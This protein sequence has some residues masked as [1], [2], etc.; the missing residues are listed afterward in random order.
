MLNHP[1]FP[2]L[3][4]YLVTSFFSSFIKTHPHE[5]I[6]TDCPTIQWKEDSSGFTCWAQ[7]EAFFQYSC[8]RDV[9]ALGDKPINAFD[10]R[11]KC[12]LTLR[13]LPHNFLIATPVILKHSPS[14]VV[15][16]IVVRFINPFSPRRHKATPDVYTIEVEEGQRFR[17]M[18]QPDGKW[19]LQ[20]S[21]GKDEP[22][23]SINTGLHGRLSL[24][25]SHDLKKLVVLQRNRISTS[26]IALMYGP[27]A[28]STTIQVFSSDGSTDREFGVLS[29][30]MNGANQGG[31][32][33]A[34][35]MVFTRSDVG[36]GLREDSPHTRQRAIRSLIGGNVTNEQLDRALPLLCDPNQEVRQTAADLFNR[37]DLRSADKAMKEYL[38]SRSTAIKELI[39]NSDAATLE[40]TLSVIARNPEELRET[41]PAIVELRSTET[42]AEKASLRRS[43]AQAIAVLRRHVAELRVPISRDEMVLNSHAQAISFTIKKQIETEPSEPRQEFEKAKSLKYTSSKKIAAGLIYSEKKFRVVRVWDVKTGVKKYDILGNA[44]ETS[45]GLRRSPIMRFWI[46]PDES[47]L[48]YVPYGR[49]ETL[50]AVN[51]D[52][53]ELVWKIEGHS[54]VFNLVFAPSSARIVAQ[55]SYWRHY[56]D[57]YE[58]FVLDARSG[59]VLRGDTLCEGRPSCIGLVSG[60]EY[61]VVG[62]RIYRLEKKEPH[63]EL[64]ESPVGK[65]FALIDGKLWVWNHAQK[66]LD[67]FELSSGAKVFEL[68]RRDERPCLSVEP[69]L[70]SQIRCKYQDGAVVVW[71]TDFH[72]EKRKSEDALRSTSNRRNENGS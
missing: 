29:A 3:F 27:T 71:S 55:T 15:K 7:K 32:Q 46:S 22:W 51:L 58:C 52:T 54:R 36:A 64:I 49:T 61:L 72:L 25:S 66:S 10:R 65:P 62:S 21:D 45:R 17:L 50:N 31:V 33:A 42:Y 60:G 43:Q 38:A 56:G 47:L 1:E 53:G 39:E 18:K 6:S 70:G 16:S 69:A 48:I 67:G 37:T 44:Y 23:N 40:E 28:P 63:I 30:K 14:A 68:T 5:V 12:L 24:A 20:H 59:A 13:S 41:W 35:P 34:Y 19:S 2:T 11:R 26:N 9:F 4:F 8:E 57:T